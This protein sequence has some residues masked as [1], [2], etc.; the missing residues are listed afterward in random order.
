MN[1]LSYWSLVNNL[2]L[3]TRLGNFRLTVHEFHEHYI[4]YSGIFVN[5]SWTHLMNVHECSWAI[6]FMIVH[7]LAL[8]HEFSEFMTV[9]EQPMFMNRISS[10][11]H[12]LFNNIHEPFMNTCMNAHSFLFTNIHE[13]FITVHD[14]TWTHMRFGMEVIRNHQTIM[15]TAKFFLW[16]PSPLWP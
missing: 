6:W 3:L 9:H 14:H 2:N 5:S 11:T 1:H 10:W 7:E 13:L 8:V 16:A 12:L 4:C 15:V